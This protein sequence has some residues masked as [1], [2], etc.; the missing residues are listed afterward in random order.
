MENCVDHKN[1]ELAL[2]GSSMIDL[3]GKVVI[4]HVKVLYTYL[5]FIIS[6]VS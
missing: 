6:K 3:H 2:F 5:C 4:E 1:I